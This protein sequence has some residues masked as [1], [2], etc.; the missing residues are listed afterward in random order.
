MIDWLRELLGED[1]TINATEIPE[2]LIYTTWIK[3][4][5]GELA[6][7]FLNVQDHKPLGPEEKTRRR[8]ISFPRV[9]RPITLLLRGV[10]VTGGAFYSP[11]SPEPV[12]CEV[13]R[14]GEDSQVTMPGGVMAM[15]GLAR[16]TLVGNG[17]AQ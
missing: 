11:D 14:I 1:E 16:L 15:Y 9:D 3:K 17:G 5:G 12:P 13:K 8:E 2:K 7:H 10:N 6:M 4:G